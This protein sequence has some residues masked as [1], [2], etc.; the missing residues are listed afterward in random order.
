MKFFSRRT[1]KEQGRNQYLQK[2]RPLRSTE[3]EIK[4]QR[5]QRIIVCICVL[6]S[7]G[8]IFFLFSSLYRFFT[9]KTVQCS[10]AEENCAV[11]EQQR[12]ES[13]KGRFIFS[14]LK[15]SHP[16]LHSQVK[17]QLPNQVK[18][19]F[20]K[21]ETLAFLTTSTGS[22]EFIMMSKEGVLLPKAGEES[23]PIIAD[24]THMLMP[25]ET[26]VDE[27][28]LHFYTQ[29]YDLVM[30]QH[31][32][33]PAGIIVHSSDEVVWRLPNSITA[34]TT[35]NDVASQLR[36]LQYL[37]QTPTIETANHTIDLRFANPVIRD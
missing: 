23:V 26:Q 10:Y 2:I 21:P 6:V 20:Q 16:F 13:L 15:V 4:R 27:R 32:A 5:I 29:V 14:S 7:T 36:S 3:K 12:A 28:T 22:G 24:D 37:L 25:L 34:L 30:N 1:Q 11:R 33:T 18:V 8:V 17:R 19:S 35:Q 9:I 31:I